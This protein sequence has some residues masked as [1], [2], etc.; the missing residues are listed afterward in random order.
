MNIY[1][2]PN[3]YYDRVVMDIS[4]IGGVKFSTLDEYLFKFPSHKRLLTGYVKRLNGDIEISKLYELFKDF[5]K[6]DYFHSEKHAELMESDYLYK[7]ITDRYVKNPIIWTTTTQRVQSYY[8][9]S[10]YLK[11]GKFQKIAR[12]NAHQYFNM[13][14]TNNVIDFSKVRTMGN[15]DRHNKFFTERFLL[16][17]ILKKFVEKYIGSDYTVVTYS[18]VIEIYSFKKHATLQIEF[19][20]WDSKVYLIWGHGVK[21]RKKSDS[22]NDIFFLLNDDQNLMDFYR[23]LHDL[24]DG[25]IRKYL[26]RF[27]SLKDEH[28]HTVNIMVGNIKYTIRELFKDPLDT[29]FTPDINAYAI[30]NGVC[31]RLH[32][33]RSGRVLRLHRHLNYNTSEEIKLC[34]YSIQEKDFNKLAGAL[35]DLGVINVSAGN[36]VDD[37]FDYSLLSSR[38][39]D[40]FAL[41]F[42]KVPTTEAS[43]MFNDYE[44]FID[45]LK[46]FVAKNPNPKDTRVFKKYDEIPEN[47]FFELTSYKRDKIR[48]IEE[49]N[50][51]QKDKYITIK[52]FLDEYRK[53][54]DF[55]SLLI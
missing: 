14:S 4:D 9:D 17:G 30:H 6:V 40:N 10:K 37:N 34:S 13:Q 19:S 36:T 23:G 35:F 21:S 3:Y 15:V 5:D 25:F 28:Q 12:K 1:A 11:V 24:D 45:Q 41:S 38:Q 32:I 27:E 8:F 54:I 55:F 44:L 51:K 52:M 18:N 43:K 26:E 2:L 50:R 42:M 7:L 48:H 53:D 31:E 29:Y 33:I 20:D 39:M 16:E 47:T 49:K 22:F 46:E